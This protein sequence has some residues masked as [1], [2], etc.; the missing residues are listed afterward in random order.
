MIP[1]LPGQEMVMTFKTQGSRF[2]RKTTKLALDVLRLRTS[3]RKGL[4]LIRLQ[5]IEVV[6]RL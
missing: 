5:K 3:K 4:K 2:K 6:K 1:S